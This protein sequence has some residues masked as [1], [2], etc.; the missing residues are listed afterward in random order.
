MLKKLLIFG[1]LFAGTL[2]A[3]AARVDVGVR[4][5]HWQRPAEQEQVFLYLASG[6]KD[7]FVPVNSYEK[8]FGTPVAYKG[9]SPIVLFLKKGEKYVPFAVAEVP[10]GA[11][12]I[13]IFLMNRPEDAPPLVVN[14]KIP[15]SKS[16]ELVPVTQPYDVRVFDY[17]PKLV[18]NGDAFLV[19]FSD[20]PMTIVA[21]NG[22][23]QKVLPGALATISRTKAERAE[24]TIS[25]VADKPP[26][27]AA[28]TDSKSAEAK[29]AWRFSSAII[30]RKSQA[31]GIFI[32]KDELAMESG[33]VQFK[34]ATI[35]DIRR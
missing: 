23:P 7:R 5:S 19:N 32:E 16:K 9:E 13:A 30:V 8:S 34:I 10:K 25:I 4:C 29:E 26:T 12:D 15:G 35:R 33:N 31:V 28:D 1:F 21:N 3:I 20:T 11:K 24:L 17:S 6:G 14:A 27:A 18:K 2:G 22:T